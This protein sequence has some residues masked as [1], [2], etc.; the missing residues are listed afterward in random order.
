V[1]SGHPGLLRFAAS[2]PYMWLYHLLHF[3]YDT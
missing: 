1:H 2:R 3:L